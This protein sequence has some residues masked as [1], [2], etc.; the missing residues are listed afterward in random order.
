MDQLLKSFSDASSREPV[1]D[2]PGERICLVRVA[3]PQ[4]SAALATAV[5]VREAHVDSPQVRSLMLRD[6]IDREMAFKAVAIDSLRV[7][8]ERSGLTHRDL[9][10]SKILEVRQV[11][12]AEVERLIQ[13][14]AAREG[15]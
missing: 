12:A 10:D 6:G 14:H 1:R 2:V 15:N 13:H 5:I 9:A 3:I 4:R 7:K 11:D 8:L